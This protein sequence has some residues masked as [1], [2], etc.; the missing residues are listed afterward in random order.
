MGPIFEFG[1][2]QKNY[3]ANFKNLSQDL[4]VKK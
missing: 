4:T 3:V 1:H 2:N